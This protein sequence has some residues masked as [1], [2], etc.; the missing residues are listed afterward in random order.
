MFLWKAW[1]CKLVTLWSHYHF[2]FQFTQIFY[3]IDPENFQ[4]EKLSTEEVALQGGFPETSWSTRGISCCW[5]MQLQWYSPY[6]HK[7]TWEKWEKTFNFVDHKICK[8]LTEN[9]QFSLPLQAYK[10][11]LS[12]SRSFVTPRTCFDLTKRQSGLTKKIKTNLRH[13]RIFNWLLLFH[14]TRHY[15]YLLDSSET[16][17]WLRFSFR[18]FRSDGGSHWSCEESIIF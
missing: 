6:Q 4:R 14:S 3:S 13:F 10:W 2:Q 1:K 9:L 12:I 17:R 15:S 16:K 18:H 8:S 7:V 5:F 11:F